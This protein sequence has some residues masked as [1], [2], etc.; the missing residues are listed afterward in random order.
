MD[1]L[2][3]LVGRSLLSNCLTPWPARDVGTCTTKAIENSSDLYI[4]R[5]YCKRPKVP[6]NCSIHSDTEIQVVVG[7]LIRLVSIYKHAFDPRF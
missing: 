1:F 5:L 6:L 2:R 7:K 4:D 3:L